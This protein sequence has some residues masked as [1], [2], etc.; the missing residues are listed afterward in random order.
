MI[1]NG[2]SDE[3]VVLEDK[4][5]NTFENMNNSDKMIEEASEKDGNIVIVTSDFHSKRSKGMLQKMTPLE[6]LTYVV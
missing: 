3:N 6:I 4:S 1:K 2:V 5:R